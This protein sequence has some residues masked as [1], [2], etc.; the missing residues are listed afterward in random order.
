M[1]A[2]RRQGQIEQAL[3]EIA[4]FGQGNWP[5]PGNYRTDLDS[6]KMPHQSAFYKIRPQLR[7]HRQFVNQIYI[8][9]LAQFSSF[10]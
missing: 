9:V 7:S 1:Q 5:E 10:L 3:A 6:F 8:T 2:P 4:G